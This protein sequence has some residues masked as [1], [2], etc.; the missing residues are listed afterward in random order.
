MK[1]IL[2]SLAILAI[3]AI[4]I[5]GNDDTHHAAVDNVVT[6]SVALKGDRVIQH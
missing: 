3:I 1:T 5:S 2:T 4:S 6:G